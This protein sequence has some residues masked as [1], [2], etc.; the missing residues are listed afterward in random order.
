MLV[1]EVKLLL[2]INDERLTIYRIVFLGGQGGAGVHGLICSTRR[3]SGENY[4]LCTER[5]RPSASRGDTGSKGAPGSSK[6]T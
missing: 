5:S 6:K 4:W 3:Q 2:I 1:K